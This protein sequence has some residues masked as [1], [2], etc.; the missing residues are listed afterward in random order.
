MLWL[1]D[2]DKKIPSSLQN[3]TKRGLEIKYCK[4]IRSYTKIFYTLKEFPNALVV[5]SDDDI[6]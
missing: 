2:T 3:L 1:S 6:F 4:D 5:T